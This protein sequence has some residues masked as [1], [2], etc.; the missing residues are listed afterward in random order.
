VLQDI[1]P[2]GVANNVVQSLYGQYKWRDFGSVDS[3]FISTALTFGWIPALLGMVGILIGVIRTIVGRATVPQVAFAA[4]IPV[5]A[6]VALVTQYRTLVFFMAAMAVTVSARPVVTEFVAEDR[7]RLGR[8]THG[9][10]GANV[11]VT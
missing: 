5:L 8:A 3:A 6:T 11:V 2:L 4:Q 7:S 9:R 10:V 1:H